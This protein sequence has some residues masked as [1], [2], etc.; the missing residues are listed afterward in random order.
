MQNMVGIECLS[1]GANLSL[2][3]LAS[4][5]VFREGIYVCMG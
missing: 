1:S 5:T 2:D 3:D 4:V